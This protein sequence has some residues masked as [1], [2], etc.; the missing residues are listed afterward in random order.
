MIPTTTEKR[1]IIMA[2]AFLNIQKQFKS[3]DAYVWQF[4]GGKPIKNAWK[5][6]K[7]IPSKTKESMAISADLK[8]WDLNS[9]ARSYVMLLCRRQGW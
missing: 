3:F 4:T 8:K 1:L 6:Q 5:N 2:R 7:E 9:Q